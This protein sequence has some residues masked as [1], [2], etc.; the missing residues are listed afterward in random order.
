M[1]A[2]EAKF[3]VI[4]P[5]LNDLLLRIQTD[6]AFYLQFRNNPE[7]ALTFYE[8]SAEERAALNRPD[9]QIWD[10]LGWITQRAKCLTSTNHFVALRSDDLAAKIALPEVEQTIAK[11]RD[12]SVHAERL[13]AVSA[14][15]EQI[16]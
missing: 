2:R 14:L 9:P 5:N 16:G 11:I 4:M 3:Q 15:V 7:E 13:A 12:L 10:R 8:L 6:Y 1:S